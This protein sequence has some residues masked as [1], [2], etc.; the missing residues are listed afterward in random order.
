MRKKRK[1]RGPGTGTGV[2]AVPIKGCKPRGI[3]RRELRTLPELVNRFHSE[4]DT[5][6]DFRFFRKL[7]PWHAV[8]EQA[9]MAMNEH[10]K[11]F[12]H[13]Y[14]LKKV[15]LKAATRRL[16]RADLKSCKDF[17]SLFGEVENAVASIKGI[18]PLY[19][20][21]TACRIGESLRLRPKRVYLHAGT[22]SGARAIGLGRGC[23]VVEM[24]ELPKAMRSLT[25]SQVEDF[26]CICKDDLWRVFS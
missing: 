12:P 26:L 3:P 19:V 5:G 21:D 4:F 17:D 7:K 11:R 22:R 13:Q 20:Y 16:H 24:D 14:R 2:C 18:G 9:G 25:P 10:G 8:I 1:H 23:A 15:A 6:A